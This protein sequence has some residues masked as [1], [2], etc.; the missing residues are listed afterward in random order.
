MQQKT[1]R[2]KL[3]NENL[4]SNASKFLESIMNNLQLREIDNEKKFQIRQ[5][6][7]KRAL[8]FKEAS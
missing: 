8:K 1:T 3:C 4:E 5:F 2:C 6:P 7:W